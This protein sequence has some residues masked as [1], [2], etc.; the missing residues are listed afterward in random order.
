[1][2]KPVNPQLP[3]SQVTPDPILEKRS[4]RVFTSEYKI[5]IV[6]E[7][8]SCVHGELTQL[9]RREKL[10]S[11]QVIHWRKELESGDTEKL[12]KSAPGPKGRFTPEQR[13]IQRLEKR[14][15]RLERELDISN[16]CIDLQK[17]AFRIL[18]LKSNESEQ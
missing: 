9:L 3:E 15:K 17:K 4:R 10:Y 7:A 14:V 13:E 5:R 11:N 6:A 1:M 18:D 2:P 12:A 8:D 16:S